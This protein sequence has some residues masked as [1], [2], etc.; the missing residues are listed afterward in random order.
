VLTT[1][2]VHVNN[3]KNQVKIIKYVLLMLSNDA[4]D[5]GSGILELEVDELP[6]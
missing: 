2:Q 6:T 5:R 1:G 3:I 4:P